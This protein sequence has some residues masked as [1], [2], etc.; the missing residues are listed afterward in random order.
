[1]SQLSFLVVF[2]YI[3]KS[4]AEILDITVLLGSLAFSSLDKFKLIPGESIK[5]FGFSNLT[6]SIYIKLSSTDV[7]T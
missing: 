6:G 2:K 5:I 4:S 7:E 3:I 1:M